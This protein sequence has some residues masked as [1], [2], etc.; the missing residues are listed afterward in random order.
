MMDT[1]KW[2]D[3]RR[4]CS[5]HGKKGNDPACT[6]CYPPSAGSMMYSMRTAQAMREQHRL[7]FEGAMLLQ[8]GSGELF[9]I[10]LSAQ[11]AVDTWYE[12]GRLLHDKDK[13]RREYREA[14]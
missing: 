5:V 12:I 9:T 7:I 4:G 2:I 3:D 6:A 1:A 8:A 13:E 14:K 10:K 11:H